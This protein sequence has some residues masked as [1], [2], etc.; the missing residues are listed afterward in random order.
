MI[1]PR[2]CVEP[3][4]S[5]IVLNVKSHPSVIW[6]DSIGVDHLRAGLYETPPNTWNDYKDFFT[7]SFAA[8]N[9]TN[10]TR[11]DFKCMRLNIFKEFM[12]HLIS[13][14]IKQG[15]ENGRVV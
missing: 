6:C 13:S 3:P 5:L 11:I 1:I 15:Q 12:T 9:P 4:E 7:N 8:A 2:R 10:E 14:D